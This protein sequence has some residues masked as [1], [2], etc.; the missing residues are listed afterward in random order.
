[1]KTYVAFTKKEI[2]LII[3]TLSESTSRTAKRI[4]RR[5]DIAIG[6]APLASMELI[7][8]DEEELGDGDDE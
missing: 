6:D 7:G 5:I 3:L 8:A 4:G 1:M 2:D